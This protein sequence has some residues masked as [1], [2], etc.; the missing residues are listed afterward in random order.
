M[1]LIEVMGLID[2]TRQWGWDVAIQKRALSCVLDRSQQDEQGKMQIRE[3]VQRIAD[4]SPRTD[5]RTRDNT[6]Q[7]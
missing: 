5:N 2:G 6:D 3:P 4:N 1:G 7:R